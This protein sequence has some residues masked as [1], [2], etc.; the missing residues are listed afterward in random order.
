MSLLLPISAR[1]VSATSVPESQGSDKGLLA[2]AG[3]MSHRRKDRG[4]VSAK[5][6]P[7]APAI[8]SRTAAAKAS[9]S[10]SVVSNEH[11]Q[12][13]SPVCSSQV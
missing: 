11:I 4:P 5:H 3:V 2:W 6:Q 9:M 12:R 1:V 8:S 7:F 10:S 13:T